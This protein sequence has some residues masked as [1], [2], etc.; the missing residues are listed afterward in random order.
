MINEIL[1]GISQ[2]ID[3]EFGEIYQIYTEVVEQGLEAPCFLLLVR[4]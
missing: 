1:Y 2:A 3:K 4:L